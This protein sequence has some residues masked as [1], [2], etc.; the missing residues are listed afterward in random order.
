MSWWAVDVRPPD[1]GRDALSAWLVA[2]TGQAVEE[3]ADGTIVTFATDEGAAD[4]LIDELRAEHGSGV[5]ASRRPLETVDW[6]TKWRDGIQ[7]R[8]FGRLTVTPTWLAGADD[9]LQVVVDPETAFGSGEHGSTRAALRLLERRLRPGDRVLDLGSGSGILAIAAIKL[10]ARV[11]IGIENDA[12]AN[13]VA[14][15]NASRNGVEAQVEF[16]DGHA[17]TLAPLAGP[18]DLLLSNI[19]RTV[20]TSLLPAIVAALSPDGVAIFSGME[21][22]EAELFRP[23]LAAAGLEPIEEALDTGWWAIAVRRK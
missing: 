9:G 12:E 13:A 16:L 6:S 17:A 7:S 20:N 19:L 21:A 8:R 11:A 5:T 4:A 1:D 18:A 23:P 22:A 2:R 10:G 15:R 14:R 3:R